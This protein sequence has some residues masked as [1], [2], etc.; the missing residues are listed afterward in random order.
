[1]VDSEDRYDVADDDDDYLDDNNN[2]LFY[3]YWHYINLFD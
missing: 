1:L 3:G 2:D